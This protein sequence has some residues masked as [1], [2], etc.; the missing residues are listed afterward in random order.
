[1]NKQQLETLWVSAGGPASSSDIA[2]AIALAE[3]GGDPTNVG[4]QGTSFG[5][6]QIHIPA[7]PQYNAAQLKTPLYNAQAAV[8]ISSHGAN[9]QPWSTY[10]SGAYKQYLGS[11]GSGGILNTNVLGV[12]PNDVLGAANDALGGVPGNAISGISSVGSA[13]G[14]IFSA[15]GMERILKI[16][17]GGLICLL[18]INELIKSAG[19]VSP[20]PHVPKVV[21]IP[22]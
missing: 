2:S 12:S 14:F 4:D 7:H 5:L 21:P 15:S 10:N 18:A 22:V 13:L 9:W 16:T 17:G 1:M 20:V 8:A 6:W 3:S 19:N 11:G